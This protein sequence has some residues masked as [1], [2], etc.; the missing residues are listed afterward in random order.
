MRAVRKDYDKPNRC[1]GWSGSG[2]REYPWERSKPFC[3]GGPSGY[4]ADDCNNWRVHQCGTCGLRTLPYVTRYI[5]PDWYRVT[6][7]WW[8]RLRDW[9]TISKYVDT[10]TPFMRVVNFVRGTKYEIREMNK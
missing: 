5:D 9:V 7:L 10:E 8:Y 4:Y 3:D 2:I 6:P 1:P